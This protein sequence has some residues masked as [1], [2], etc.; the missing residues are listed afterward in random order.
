[1]AGISSWPKLVSAY[2][3]EGGELGNTF[4]IT[5]PFS[6]RSRSRALRTL[7]EIAGISL[8]NSPKR[9]EV[10]LKY[11]MMLG[12][13]AP[14][15]SAMH[16]VNG[17]VGGTGGALFLRTFRDI[18]ENLRLPRGYLNLIVTSSYG[19]SKSYPM[20]LFIVDT[21]IRKPTMKLFYS[22][23]A[24]SLSPHII[25]REAGQAFDLERVDGATKK[26]ETGRDF[27]V[28][29]PKGYVPVLELDSGEILTEGAAIVQYV[30][31]THGAANLAPKTGTLERARLQEHLNFVASELH[32]AFSPLFDPEAPDDQKKAAPANIGRR[33]DYVEPLFADGRHYLLGNNFSVADAYL[34]VVAGWAKPT[35]IGLDRWPRLQ[36]FHDRVGGRPAVKAAMTAEGLI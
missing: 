19:V 16:S 6:Q 10:A 30:A 33:F 12:V 18:A 3:T 29:N 11:Q 24:C 23:G 14:P 36:A 31:D 4:R 32:K 2:S 20:G 27:K 9:R 35:G 26:T 15:S 22:P 13:Q 34:F 21:N 28:I 8:R 5:T 7:A 17:Q 25:L 1:M